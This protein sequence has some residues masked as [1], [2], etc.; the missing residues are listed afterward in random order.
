MSLTHT[1]ACIHNMHLHIGVHA[2]TH[3]HT[4]PCTD[5][6]LSGLQK[7]VF[8]PRAEK[9]VKNL[10]EFC[11]FHLLFQVLSSQGRQHA[12]ATRRYSAALSAPLLYR[13]DS[14]VHSVVAMLFTLLP[15]NKWR[16][17]VTLSL[18][19]TS[20]TL[21]SV[22]FFFM[23]YHLCLFVVHLCLN[24]NRGYTILVCF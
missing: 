22:H 18:C 16:R 11:S 24:V 23:I 19:P 4:L 10:E 21:S 3:T 9:H 8:Q 7:K 6:R 15:V 20:T 1:H 13:C 12:L 2:Q 14:L 17:S 5:L